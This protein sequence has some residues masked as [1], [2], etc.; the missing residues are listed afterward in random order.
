MQTRKA[1]KSLSNGKSNYDRVTASGPLA[2]NA[3]KFLELHA[4]QQEQIKQAQLRHEVSASLP[5]LAA[6]KEKL[7]QIIGEK[8]TNDSPIAM[9]F[10]VFNVVKK[11]SNQYPQDIGLKRLATNL[12]KLWHEDPIGT[13]S[14]K[15][16]SAIRDYYQNQSPRSI[17]SNVI[18][19]MVPKIAF[20][21]LPVANLVRIAS[22]INSQM[23]YDNAI[24]SHGFAGNDIN[25]I[26]ART[27][28]R[29]LVN[30][31]ANIVGDSTIN[32]SQSVETRVANKIQ[33]LAQRDK[34]TLLSDEDY[35]YDVFHGDYGRKK[36]TKYEQDLAKEPSTH[37]PRGKGDFPY[38]TEEIEEIREIDEPDSY[39]VLD[40][41]TSET[42]L[43][44]EMVYVDWE[45]KKS[46]DITGYFITDARWEDGESVSPDDIEELYKNLLESSNT[47]NESDDMLTNV[48]AKEDSGKSQPEFN[49]EINEQQESQV[50]IKPSDGLKVLKAHAV[51]ANY[52]L[53]DDNQ[54]H[55]LLTSSKS[56]DRALTT[57]ANMNKPPLW[58]LGSKQELFDLVKSASAKI[59]GDDFIKSKS[60]GKDD[61]KKKEEKK[62][63]FA[64]AS[65][66]G[67]SIESVED[68][69]YNNEVVKF[70]NSLELKVTP[71]NKIALT[72]N[73]SSKMYDFIDI[74]SAISDFVY[75]V[76]TEKNKEIPP[77][78]FTV[79]EGFRINCPSCNKHNNFVMP[80][81]ATNLECNHC[82]TILTAKTIK[83]AFDQNLATEQIVITAFV[84]PAAQEVM[85]DKFAEAATIA[86]ADIVD[87]NGFKVEAAIINPSDDKL[88]DAW[89]YL[90][91][92]GFKAIAQ[93]MSVPAMPAGGM[94]AQDEIEVD[95][96]VPMPVEEGIEDVNEMIP[97]GNE[98]GEGPEGGQKW[99]D[100]QMVQA[101]MMHYQSQG[102][103][104]VEAI[105]QFSK[106]YGD[107][108]DPEMVIQIAATIFD[109]GLDKVKIAIN[110]NAGDLPSTSVNTQQP[111]SVSVTK[112]VIG[113][114]S[115]T[116]GEIKTPGKPKT[117]VTPQGTFSNTST[118]P[119]SD[120]KDPGAFGAPKP[121]AQ[122]P[123]TDQKGTSLSDTNM[124]QHS[125][126]QMGKMM[127]DM[128]SKSKAAPQS[129]QSK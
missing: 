18:N 51:P 41:G 87:S 35:G 10:D 31:K 9:R 15:S 20:N 105:H 115:D 12:E 7:N 4:S 39:E 1:L 92:A 81:E 85:G 120:N 95:M 24:I 80:K 70:G 71:E 103:N 101:A 100:H 60:Q 11:A 22:Q 63:P 40:S 99:A 111:D 29:E 89:D 104:V 23:D 5:A 76:G 126:S 2:A 64:K 16:L 56:C 86:G 78:M 26:R 128:D 62:N 88:A 98:L 43:H 72:A 27:F 67:Y 116:H 49:P 112:N 119:D 65:D 34:D 32:Q 94:T 118:E 3:S 66:R 25:S 107:G 102:N 125:D 58:W 50:K 82:N 93:D 13:I 30:K 42:Y 52:P 110:K 106:D 91:N 46:D 37:I 90:I 21:N 8:I 17:L 127:R 48:A 38:T 121:K 114:D 117:Q 77:S 108:F 6:A 69:I 33:K 96:N 75:M 55:I 84:P 122:H 54:D 109:I 123:A 47:S 113:P 44:D 45:L 129:M 68:K 79:R 28:I 19:E 124:G 74:E 61:K 57:I 59:A 53:V 36:P 83:G 97:D 73:G 14:A